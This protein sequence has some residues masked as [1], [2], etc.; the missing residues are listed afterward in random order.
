[1]NTCDLESGSLSISD[2]I[3]FGNLV[4]DFNTNILDEHDYVPSDGVH[5]I[6]VACDN[7]C[8]MLSKLRYQ[9]FEEF[10]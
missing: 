1:M 9:E 4:T 5:S 2:D 10:C 7:V 8:G 3:D 6:K